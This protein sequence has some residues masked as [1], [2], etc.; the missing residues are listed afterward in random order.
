VQQ[1]VPRTRVEF[2][3]EDDD[4]DDD[5]DNASPLAELMTAECHRRSCDL[6]Y[7]NNV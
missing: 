7:P 1:L 5:D 6:T 4:D 2:K 3:G